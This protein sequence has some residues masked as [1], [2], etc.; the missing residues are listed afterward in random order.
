MFDVPAGLPTDLW[1]IPDP[2]HRYQTIEVPESRQMPD[3]QIKQKV[4]KMMD[5]YYS[6]CFQW[7]TNAMVHHLPD[8]RDTR[9]AWRALRS[10]SPAPNEVP[11]CP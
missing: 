3:P 6:L 4:K 10:A 8:P 11:E 9:G 2:L 7:I 5:F 1:Y